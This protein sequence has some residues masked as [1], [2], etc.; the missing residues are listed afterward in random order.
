MI[1][2]NLS[3]LLL[4]FSAPLS[5]QQVPDTNWRFDIQRP[6]FHSEMN[7]HIDEGHNNFHTKDGGFTG[8][9]R[10]LEQDG[11]KVHSLSRHFADT[12][13]P[14][15][16]DLLVISNAL[17]QLNVQ[18]WQLPT[19]S[20]FTQQE[21]NAIKQW[22]RKGGSL[23]LIAD[24]MPFAG[25][26]HDLAEAFGFQ[27]Q[28]GFARIG[29][30]MF[31]SPPFTV[32]HQDL[33]PDLLKQDCYPF[34]EVDSV[35]SFTGSAFEKPRN[36]QSILNF[37]ESDTTF[38]TEV[39][40]RFTDAT[41]IG[42]YNFHQGA[43]LEYGQGKIAV[44]GEAAMFTTQL[45]NGKLKVGMNSPQAKYNAPFVLNLIHWLACKE[46]KSPQSKD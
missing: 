17:N 42:L 19:P 10:L 20:A 1:M 39:A 35:V 38:Q 40:W 41:A 15:T 27:F 2:K 14:S 13:L 28:N 44:F 9:S 21:I 37:H 26:A 43:I 33:H 34:Y 16:S 3:L 7:I 24:H 45:A 12:T 18:N 30:N 23:L 29:P 22:V 36:A 11:A 8:F 46:E 25:A 4:L 5:A 6:A 32:L 31:P